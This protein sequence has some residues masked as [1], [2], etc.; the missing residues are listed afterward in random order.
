MYVYDL[1]RI[2]FISSKEA[3]E[4]RSVI[5]FMINEASVNHN[6]YEPRLFDDYA[7]IKEAL[8]DYTPLT[9]TNNVEG[10]EIVQTT[11]TQ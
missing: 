4:Y 7:D 2:A 8:R 1:D 10:E 11:T 9:L 3:L 6:Q 5:S